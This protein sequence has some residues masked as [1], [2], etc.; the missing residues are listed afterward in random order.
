MLFS[1]ISTRK[2]HTAEFHGEVVR[3]LSGSNSLYSNGNAK[4]NDFFFSCSLKSVLRMIYLSRTLLYLKEGAFKCP[5]W[6]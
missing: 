3:I 4:K 2:T 5:V 6:F 1:C